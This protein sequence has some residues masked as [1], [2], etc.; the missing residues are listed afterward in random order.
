M[1]PAS[2]ERMTYLK[3]KAANCPWEGGNGPPLTLEEAFE[4][5]ANTSA[6]R[7]YLPDDH[8]MKLSCGRMKD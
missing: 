3:K 7:P 4:L 8:P 1:T 5:Y 2:P 6:F